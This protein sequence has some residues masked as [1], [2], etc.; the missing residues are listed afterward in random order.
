[1]S[2][3]EVHDEFSTIVK[4]VYRPPGLSPSERTR[5]LKECMEGFMERNGFS[6]DLKL[7]EK[8]EPGH[9]AG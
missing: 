8:A 2:V 4:S 6:I 7:M 1:M 9:C 5:K 3:E